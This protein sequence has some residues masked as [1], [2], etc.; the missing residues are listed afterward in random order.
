M[1]S[2]H[3]EEKGHWPGFHPA[4]IRLR[5]LKRVARTGKWMPTSAGSV[6]VGVFTG[7]PVTLFC[8][9]GALLTWK[10]FQPFFL[11]SASV[12]G[13]VEQPQNH[14]LHQTTP[15]SSKVLFEKFSGP[16]GRFGI[17]E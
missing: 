10:G 8:G 5:I 12:S 6:G 15:E 4:R 17:T 16:A 9:L 1:T 7:F 11:T 3:R 14:F 2:L 13:I